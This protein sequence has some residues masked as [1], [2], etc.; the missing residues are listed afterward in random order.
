LWDALIVGGEDHKIAHADDAKERWDRLESWARQRWPH[1]RE[2]IYRWS[3]QVLEPFD[4]AAFI[5]PNPDGAEN[6]YMA[7]GDSGQGLTHGTIAGVLL[8]DLIMGRGNPWATVYDP[9]RVSLRAGPL[10]EMAK[11]NVDVAFRFAKDRLTPGDV[12]SESEIPR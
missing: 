9:K 7:S 1:A 12:R 3:G 2:V 5:G 6:V 10:A 4:Y 11:D 8:T